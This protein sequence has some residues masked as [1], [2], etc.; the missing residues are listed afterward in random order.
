MSRP[1][2]S[3]TAETGSTISGPP[4]VLVKL[5]EAKVLPKN[6]NI[7]VRAPYHAEHLYPDSDLE[8]ILEKIPSKTAKS[9]SGRIPIATS[10]SG[11]FILATSFQDLM[12]EALVDI[13]QKPLR[14]DLLA[15]GLIKSLLRDRESP[16]LILPIATTTSQIFVTAFARGGLADVTVDKSMERTKQSIEPDVTPG[17][18]GR[19]KLAI[20]GFSGRFPDAKDSEAF[21]QILREGRDV[22]SETPLTRW[23]IDTH[24]DPT[25]TKKNTSGT[26]YGCYLQD[27]GLFDARFFGMSPREAPQVDPAQRLALLTTY[28]AME[29]AGMVP[30]ATPSTQRDRVG[31]F[32]GTTSND[33][34][35]TNSSQDIDT[36]YIPGS[37][38]AFIPGRQ[39]YFFRFSGPSYSVDTA[40]SSSLAAMHIACNALLRGDID[41]AISGGTN[42]M[43]NPGK[44]CQQF[45]GQCNNPKSL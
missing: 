44:S 38:R 41:V 15:E 13:L 42:V 9:S 20:V 19:S 14:L 17:D 24:V 36:Y 30:D 10:R 39:N 34:G 1:Y 37:C 11:E 28:E 4:N 3:A 25:G 27:P 45:T 32:F 35:E 18:I 26:P 23:N 8:A 33:W 29:N 7:E 6:I 40:C 22:A 12:R 21:W 2:V 16:F 43:T 31:V 5:F